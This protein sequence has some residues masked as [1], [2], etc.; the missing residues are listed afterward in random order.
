MLGPTT[1][2]HPQPTNGTLSSSVI[3][4]E[5]NYIPL[6]PDIVR[7][8]H[9]YSCILTSCAKRT[10]TPTP[11]LHPCPSLL[12]TRSREKISPSWELQKWVTNWDMSDVYTC[13]TS[14]HP[15]P[16]IPP[17]F[18]SSVIVQERKL[19]TPYIP[20]LGSPEMSDKLR[21]E[22]Q[23][24]LRYYPPIIH[25]LSLERH[26]TTSPFQTIH[27]ERKTTTHFLSHWATHLQYRS[28]HYAYPLPQQS[29]L[30][31]WSSYCTTDTHS[32]WSWWREKK[33]FLYDY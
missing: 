31:S 1:P 12:Y 25:E 20:F 9:L 27:L 30:L 2:T 11:F 10:H 16:F 29:L 32:H 33:D 8:A 23:I 24:I 28:N 7:E 22:W 18:L 13:T 14:S 26:T 6:H 3:V 4:Q 15:S 19:Y 5:R 21:Y 17:H